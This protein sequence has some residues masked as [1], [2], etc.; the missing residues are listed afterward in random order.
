MRQM[1]LEF[2][3]RAAWLSRELTR[4][5]TRGSSDTEPAM[6]AV[7]RDYGIPFSALHRL[8]YRL[9]QC[10]SICAAIYARLESAYL[11]ECERQQNKLAHEI[12]VAKILAGSLVAPPDAG[13]GHPPA[14]PSI[15]KAVDEPDGG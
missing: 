2:V 5:K 14:A 7:E 11:A 15:S 10:K 4:M 1:S 8:R 12:E 6:R 3:E 9:P 13:L